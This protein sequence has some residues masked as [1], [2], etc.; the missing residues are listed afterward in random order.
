M[1][2][3]SNFFTDIATIHVPLAAYWNSNS[4]KTWKSY[5]KHFIAQSVGQC[6]IH[7]FGILKYMLIHKCTI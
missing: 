5:G 7:I 6:G 2:K 3:F 4:K 1:K